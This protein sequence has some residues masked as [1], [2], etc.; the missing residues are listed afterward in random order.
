MNKYNVIAID[1]AKNVFQVC[2]TD[3]IGNIIY[4]KEVNRKKLQNILIQEKTSLV[5]MESCASTHY[6]A[7]F[8]KSQGHTVKAIS[9]R[10]VKGFLQG[11]KTDAND[12]IAISIAALQPN[13]KP[14]RL[15][16]VKEQ[17]LQCLDRSRSLLTK[18]KVA[19][20]NQ[21]RAQLLEFGFPI[22]PSDKKLREDIP[23]ILGDAENELT[24]HFRFSLN[25][26]L[27][28]FIVTLETLNKISNRCETAVN[29]DKSCEKLMKIEGVGPVGALGLAV[30][31]G[32]VNHFK[33]GRE[34]SACIGVTPVQHSSGGKTRLGSISKSSTNKKLR[35]CLYLGALGVVSKLKNR[36][37]RT[38]REA[39]IKS[40]LSRRP[41]KVVAI[42]LINKII[43]TAYAMLKYN[44][45]Y[46]VIPLSGNV[47]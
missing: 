40:M 47:A 2:K 28:F 5:A 24:G 25:A 37:P 45:E 18:Q 44:T 23:M 7:K 41:C 43:R 19:L 39:W 33:N 11:Q 42:A 16:S 13:V 17:S 46:K 38:E 34:A 15:V 31:L 20:A 4:N 30:V 36:E 21:M 3:H 26:M 8:A 22:A 12:A 9:A 35:A 29:E 1:L 32:D 10:I 14:C 6:W 27:E